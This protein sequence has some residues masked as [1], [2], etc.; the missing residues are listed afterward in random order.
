MVPHGPL[1]RL[2]SCP[3]YFGEIVDWSGF[4]LATWS[5]GGLLFALWTAANLVPRAGRE[6]LDTH[7]ARAAHARRRIVLIDGANK[8]IEEVLA[9]RR[10]L[11]SLGLPSLRLPAPNAASGP[12]GPRSTAVPAKAARSCATVAVGK[13]LSRSAR[14][15]DTAGAEKEVPDTLV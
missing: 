15:P 3:N 10:K 12:E 1:F 11:P 8:D 4:A 14:A 2:V 6:S 5:P 9:P 7:Q 13:E